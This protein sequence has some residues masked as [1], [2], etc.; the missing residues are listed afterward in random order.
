MADRMETLQTF[1]PET[2]GV[3][4]Q[5]HLPMKPRMELISCAF[6]LREKLSQPNTVL[7]LRTDLTPGDGG[8]LLDLP[9]K[10]APRNVVYFSQIYPG[11]IGVAPSLDYAPTKTN[12]NDILRKLPK[13][14]GLRWG[15]GTPAEII[16]IIEHHLKTTDQLLLTDA[17]TYTEGGPFKHI[18]QETQED[19]F[20]MVA[21][22]QVSGEGISIVTVNPWR[23]NR[24][25]G[26]GVFVL[27][28]PADSVDVTQPQLAGQP[29][30]V[31]DLLEK[32]A[33]KGSDFMERLNRRS[34]AGH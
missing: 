3:L 17:Y 8:T 10:E 4:K 30:T 22:G 18:P 1:S 5:A 28:F 14:D 6:T 34:L 32:N 27:G 31:R 21:V 11:S 24:I 12:I 19:G 26:L 20:R 25:S 16:E 29:R 23:F 13:I 2:L 33:R 15:L 7:S 9:P